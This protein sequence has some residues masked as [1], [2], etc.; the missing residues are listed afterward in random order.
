MT[1]VQPGALESR[2][3]LLTRDQ[4]ICHFCLY[5]F[6]YCITDKHFNPNL[7]RGGVNLHPP[8]PKAVLLLQLKNGWR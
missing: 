6:L 4:K 3:A 5:N 8:P 1:R 2:V 7:Y